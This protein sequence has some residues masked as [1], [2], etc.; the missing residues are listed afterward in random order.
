MCPEEVGMV[1]V[2]VLC[3][4]LSVNFAEIVLPFK[5]L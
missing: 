2:N 1:V 4:M 3:T 5:H